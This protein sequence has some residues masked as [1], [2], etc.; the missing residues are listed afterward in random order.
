MSN[1]CLFINYWAKVNICLPTKDE[2]RISLFHF[3]WNSAKSAKLFS[4]CFHNILV[5]N[6]SAIEID[7]TFQ[8]VPALCHCQLSVANNCADRWTVA[9]TFGCHFETYL[10]QKS[11]NL[12]R[13]IGFWVSKSSI[14]GTSFIHRNLWMTTSSVLPFILL[15]IVSYFEN[16]LNIIFKDNIP[17]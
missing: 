12:C 10:F 3:E 7:L 13:S 17:L 5:D 2:F 9:F 1:H 11:T 8:Q 6:F 15:P 16:R 14:W 4:S